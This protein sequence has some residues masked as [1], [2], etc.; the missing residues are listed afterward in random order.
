M[1]AGPVA[2]SDQDTLT[3]VAPREQRQRQHKRRQQAQD[4]VEHDGQ[5]LPHRHVLTVGTAQVP[6]ADSSHSPKLVKATITASIQYWL[7]T[8]SCGSR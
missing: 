2:Q 7:R 8:A 3:R 4:G 5:T 6:T 1:R